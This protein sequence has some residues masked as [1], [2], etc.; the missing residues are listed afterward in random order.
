MLD[1]VSVVGDDI[2]IWPGRPSL[3]RADFD[4]RHRQMFGDHTTESLGSLSVGVVGVSGSGSP[5]V[6]MLVRLGVR[7]V[8]LIEPDHVEAKNPNRLY[9]AT[10]RPAAAEVNQARELKHHVDRNGPGNPKPIVE[11]T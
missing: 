10:R 6:E 3:T 1:R 4:V 9:G 11:G 5:T 8:V 2:L 7:R